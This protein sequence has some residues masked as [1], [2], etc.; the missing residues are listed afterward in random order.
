MST[1]LMKE[2]EQSPSADIRRH[3]LELHL[4]GGFSV[5][6]HGELLDLP[7]SSHRLLVYLALRERPQCRAV[8]AGSLWPNKTE[9]RAGANLRS[10]LWRLQSFGNHRF[11]ESSGSTLSLG[12]HV[13]VDVRRVEHAG[14]SLVR[15]TTTVSAEI[16]PQLFLLELLPGWYDD[17]VIMERERLAQLQLHFLEALTTAMLS[18]GRVA[19]ALDVA[20]RLV[21]IDP[22]RERSQRALI[23]VYRAEGSLGQAR[24]QLASYRA[25][26]LDTFGCEPSADLLELVARRTSRS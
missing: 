14:W 18:E 6:D 12:D 3:K 7:E 19:E 8:V 1:L 21:A 10:S 9:T 13:C 24:R 15:G 26:M 5:T 2:A 20:V 25:L 4:L 23:T 17:W 16:E 11:I 22:L